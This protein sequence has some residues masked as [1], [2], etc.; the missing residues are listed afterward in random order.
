MAI[1]AMGCI[2]AVTRVLGFIAGLGIL[3]L[4]IGY[5]LIEVDRFPTPGIHLFGWTL[6]QAGAI[7]L[8]A[9]II[10]SD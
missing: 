4:A 2:L 9:G 3:L 5:W 7:A 6:V 1:T 10:A 8:T